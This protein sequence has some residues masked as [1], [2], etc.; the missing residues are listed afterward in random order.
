MGD[1][2]AGGA[3][4]EVNEVIRL[5]RISSCTCSLLLFGEN[6]LAFILHKLARLLSLSTVLSLRMGLHCLA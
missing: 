3:D 5:G 4:A 2:T 1:G 6:V